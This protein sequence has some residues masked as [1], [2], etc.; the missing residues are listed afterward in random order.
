MLTL[1]PVQRVAPTSKGG[2]V[3]LKPKAKFKTLSLKPVPPLG[4][5]APVA[6][7]ETLMVPSA[8]LKPAVA[9]A[10]QPTP[11]TVSASEPAQQPTQAVETVRVKSRH[12]G[13]GILPEHGFVRLPS[14]LQ[15][16]PISRA[17]WWA[18]VKD[19]TLPAGVLLSARVRAW[20]V[21]DIRRLI[22]DA[23]QA[24]AA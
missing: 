21:E 5:V 6:A 4:T 16:Y 18:G 14:I 10:A 13:F 11:M 12:Q 2:L 17:G 23:K 9:G 7:A 3:K 20:A 22:A 1:S 15:V 8:K 24:T 19:G